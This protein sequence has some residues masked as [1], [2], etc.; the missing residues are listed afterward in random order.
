MPQRGDQKKI[1]WEQLFKLMALHCTEE[2]ICGIIDVSDTTLV[3]RIKEK[4][5]MT[6]QD[7][8]K[9]KSANGKLSLRRKQYSVAM[10]GDKALLI[11]L[12][13]QWLKQTEKNELS[14]GD[15]SPIQVNYNIKK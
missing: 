3:Q 2:E 6:F 13:K 15:D 4:Y 11:W 9:L 12:G 14:T 8:F 7:L 1:D 5:D 10:A